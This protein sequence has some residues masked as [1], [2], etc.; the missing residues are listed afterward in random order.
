MPRKSKPGIDWAAAAAD[1][2]AGRS[3]TWI[4][5][6]HN[7]SRQA[8][9]K[10]AE[11]EGWQRTDEGAALAQTRTG[12]RLFDPREPSDKR[13][14]ASGSRSLHT[15]QRVLDALRLGATRGIAARMVG[16]DLSNLQRWI[17]DDPEFAAMADAAEADTAIRRIERLE[18]AGERGDTQADRWLLERSPA[19]R[20][21]FAAPR[22]A[23]PSDGAGIT[24]NLVLGGQ[25]G[26]L[27]Q[28][29]GDA[30]E[31]IEIAEQSRAAR[32]LVQ[33]AGQRPPVRMVTAPPLP[34]AAPAAGPT[35][36]PTEDESR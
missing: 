22:E 33:S 6:R 35:S 25:G 28:R 31:V 3:N 34:T 16:T 4:G 12:K 20:A 11:K 14:V 13:L 32:T 7:V 29:P 30:A 19:T 9:A 2:A 18:A 24:L 1:F 26:A 21:D 15:M 23:W 5:K 27:V 17:T 10:R 36:H 8:V